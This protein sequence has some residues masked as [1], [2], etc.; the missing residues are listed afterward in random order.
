M[1]TFI[2]RFL[3]HYGVYRR[4]PL[5]RFPAPPRGASL[6]SERHLAVN[7][8]LTITAHPVLDPGQRAGGG[9]VAW[10]AIPPRNG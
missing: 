3:M 1:R 10:K 7:Q 8:P 4:Y 9:C 2:K 6:S 5:G